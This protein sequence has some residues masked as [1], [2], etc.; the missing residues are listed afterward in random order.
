M[1]CQPTT[2]PDGLAASTDVTEATLIHFSH[3]Q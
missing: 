1:S 3:M 2:Q